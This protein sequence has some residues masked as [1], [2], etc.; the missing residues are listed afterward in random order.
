MIAMVDDD[1]DVRYRTPVTGSRK[2]CCKQLTGLVVS[3]HDK[4]DNISEKGEKNPQV[5]PL[6]WRMLEFGNTFSSD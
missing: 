3:K 1:I 6:I 4:S 2:L 5:H